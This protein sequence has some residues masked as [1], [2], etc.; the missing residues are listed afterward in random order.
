MT[1]QWKTISIAMTL[2]VVVCSNGPGAEGE[3]AAAQ[4]IWQTLD[5]AGIKKACDT[6]QA[7]I[8]NHSGNFPGLEKKPPLKMITD[9]EGPE[10][11]P[12]AIAAKI[13]AE[14]DQA[15]QKIKAIKY[16]ATVG[17]N[18]C[19]RE[20]IDEEGNVVRDDARSKEIVGALLKAMTDCTASVRLAAVEA[21]MDMSTSGN[22]GE[23]K[24]K[25]STALE[26]Y[27]PFGGHFVNASKKLSKTFTKAVV[28]PGIQRASR[29]MARRVTRHQA[30]G[31]GCT[32]C[33]ERSCCNPAIVD[34]LAK[35]AYERRSDGCWYEPSAR[36]RKAAQET[37]Q[38][39]CPSYGP[40]EIVEEE[41]DG[42]RERRGDD[43][44]RGDD[45]P[46]PADPVPNDSDAADVSMTTDPAPV[47]R[48]ALLAAFGESRE[49][50]ATRITD[51]GASVN[52][53]NG[54][55]PWPAGMDPETGEPIAIY[56]TVWRIDRE[57][58]TVE[59]H[60]DNNDMTVPTGSSAEVFHRYLLGVRKVA[61]LQV[62]EFDAGLVEARQAAGGHLPRIAR[63]DGVAILPSQR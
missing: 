16:L 30:T 47:P 27:A 4:T 39:C 56:G 46:E 10:G 60:L 36:V 29:Q 3:A 1:F 38:L 57:A 24:Q 8:V 41:E 33:Q 55:D 25:W 28:P 17:C 48:S 31:Q 21:V 50:V 34:Q 37:L 54:L 32:S 45:V 20:E 18:S 35:M 62:V 6:L 61:S 52:P 49:V 13:K 15:A 9:A 59:I 2:A 11:G 51:D 23:R 53:R 5:V 19:I 58:G 42:D 40:I 44:G 26:E 43:T 63:G 7:K 12:A 14:E 22:C